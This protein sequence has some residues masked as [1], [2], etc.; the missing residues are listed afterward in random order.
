MMMATPP[1]HTHQDGIPSDQRGTDAPRELPVLLSLI[2]QGAG[3]QHANGQH[4]A[5]LAS[6]VT[7]LVAQ[8][9]PVTA[10]PLSGEGERASEEYAFADQMS[11][12]LTMYLQQGFRRLLLV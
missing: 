4:I 2:E 6:A 1:I 8:R 9:L 10:A 7:R 5:S 11:S 12:M 3:E